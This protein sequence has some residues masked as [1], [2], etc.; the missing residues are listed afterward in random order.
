MR[1]VGRAFYKA[2]A[3][4]DGPPLRRIERDGGLFTTG[5]ANGFDRN[6]LPNAFFVSKLN[7]REPFVLCMLA[8]LTALRRIGEL[9]IAEESLL[10]RR[11]H[12]GLT[13][14]D[15]GEGLILE[16]VEPRCGCGACK[17]RVGFGHTLY[18]VFASSQLKSCRGH[19]F[20][21]SVDKN[22]ITSTLNLSQLI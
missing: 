2:S 16:F 11:P 5:S 9:L 20:K 3:A 1:I 10:A 17:D 4:V 18:A 13:T 6:L 22:D 12:E 21:M 15:A 19:G 14:V 8:A 7:R